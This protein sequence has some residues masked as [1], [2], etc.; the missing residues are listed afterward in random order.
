MVAAVCSWHEH[1]DR[2][3]Q[4]IQ[5][6]L[7]RRQR[8]VIVAPALIEA[9]SVLT[10]FP[11]PHRISP[12]EAMHILEANFLRDMKLVALGAA[13]SRSLLHASPNAGISGGCIYDAVIA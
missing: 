6:R 9:Y 7:D 11:A 4:E 3:I 2:A 12:G 13:T 8:M 1:H 5:P 10:R